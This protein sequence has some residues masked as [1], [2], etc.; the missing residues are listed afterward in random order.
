[1]RSLTV[2]CLIVSSALWAQEGADPGLSKTV[3]LAKLLNDHVVGDRFKSEVKRG[4][5]EDGLFDFQFQKT[6]VITN[7]GVYEGGVSFTIG[8]EIKQKNIR[9]KDSHSFNRDRA[10]AFR[11]ELGER[12]STGEILGYCVPVVN[13]TDDTIGQVFAVRVT[14]LTDTTLVLDK[15]E[16]FYS[17]ASPDDE[18]VVAVRSDAKII[19]TID[20]Q[21]VAK[22]T[23]QDNLTAV[24]LADGSEEKPVLE[25]FELEMNLVVEEE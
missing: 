18:D 4:T 3:Q 19:I 13:G 16:I 8:T 20:E 2:F 10:R 7:L 25:N 1:M 23:E 17:D 12:Q 24:M 21:G 9:K 22:I 6:A 14:E 15:R 5:T 11:C